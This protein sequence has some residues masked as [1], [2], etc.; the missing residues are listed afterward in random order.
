MMK[1]KAGIRFNTILLAGAVILGALVI[2]ILVGGER[3]NEHAVSAAS[4]G[5]R[6]KTDFLADRGAA[7]RRPTAGPEAAS[8]PM[9]QTPA[10]DDGAAD[11]TRLLGQIEAVL[12]ALQSANHDPDHGVEALLGDLRE[13]LRQS[14]AKLAITAIQRFLASG[15]DA[16]TGLDFAVGEAGTLE[17]SPTL[18]VFLM[19]ELGQLARGTG[20]GT[21]REV[22]RGV[23]ETK[24]SADEWAISLR[25]VAW[26]EGQSATPFLASKLHEM[27]AHTPWRENPTSGMLEAFDV[28]V[29]ARET[30]FVPSFTD[31]LRTD[32][33]P[34][35][36]AAGVA[37]DRLAE[38]APLAVMD[39]FNRNPDALADR[40]LLRADYF[41]KA[42][43]SDPAQRH[44]VETYLSRPDVS[45]PEKSKLLSG[46]AE[47]ASFVSDN[48]LSGPPPAEPGLA[49]RAG[50]LTAT[51]DWLRSGRYGELQSQIE[52]LQTQLREMPGGL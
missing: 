28:A 22:A 34:L 1:V 21:A 3:E 38:A 19:D 43:L 36:R 42:D 12:A 40:P 23:L 32:R 46:I 2:Y 11:V 45:L 41:A 52:Q 16:A 39:Y 37:L 49:R 6:E 5:A 13:T 48:L 9:D 7:T 10:A 50:L 8:T 33:L 29:Y 4:S 18:R 24:N 17:G 31:L 25:N 44:A 51:D 26:A 15:R 47:P 27:L 30:S 14:P 35:Q 20:D